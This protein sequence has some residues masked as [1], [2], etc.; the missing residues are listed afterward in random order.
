M[1]NKVILVNFLDCWVRL[2]SH[3]QEQLFRNMPTSSTLFCA[4]FWKILQRNF[5]FSAHILRDCALSLMMNFHHCQL[6][7]FSKKNGQIDF[8]FQVEVFFLH[9]RIVV[10]V[11]FIALKFSFE[12]TQHGEVFKTTGRCKVVPNED[13]PKKSLCNL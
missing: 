3:P 4:L 8:F 10:N 12:P 2:S 6:V 5:S 13:V 1:V 11:I 9:I 7:T